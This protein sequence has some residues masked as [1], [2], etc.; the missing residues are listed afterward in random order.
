[1][2]PLAQFHFLLGTQQRDL[3]D[4]LE[5][6]FHRVIQQ[7]IHRRFQIRRVLLGRIFLALVAQ[8]QIIAV[9]LGVFHFGK[10][11]VHVQTGIGLCLVQDLDAPFLQKCIERFHI[12]SAL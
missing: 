4:L 12:H 7:L 2:D 1:M 5:V 10:D 3:T 8:T 11:A 9:V 6:V